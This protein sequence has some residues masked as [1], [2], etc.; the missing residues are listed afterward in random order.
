MSTE[1]RRART[2]QMFI[3]LLVGAAMFGLLGRLYYWQ[4][5]QSGHLSQLA[6]AEHIQNLIVDA[7]RGLIYDAQGRLLATDVVRD[8]VYIEPVRFLTVDYPDAETAQSELTVLVQKLHSVLPGVAEDKL[9]KAFNSGR[10]TV[11][12]AGPI[13]PEQ[14]K[15]LRALHLPDTFLELRTWRIYPGGNL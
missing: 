13:E 15:Q 7:P 4:I 12:I 11:R 5:V 9:L 1:L 3:F 6:N 8:D 14:S 10:Q 2:R